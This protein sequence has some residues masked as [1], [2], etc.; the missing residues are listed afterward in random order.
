MTEPI[1]KQIHIEAPPEDVFP[2]LVESEK[3]LTWMGISAELDARPGGV[4]KVDPNGREIIEGRFVEV[5]PPNRVVFTWGWSEPGDMP[6]RS[7]SSRVEID[8]V[9]TSGGTLLTLKHFDVIDTMRPQH[10]EGWNYHLG[11]L[12]KVAAGQ[13]PGPD[14]CAA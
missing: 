2:Y 6:M 9:A 10:E 4:F 14:T 5:S 3:Y 8:L 13:D 12:Q 7:G 11:R 1:V